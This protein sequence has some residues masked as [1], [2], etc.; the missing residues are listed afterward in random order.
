MPEI[1]SK[2]KSKKKKSET[3]YRVTYNRT[4]LVKV[5]DKVKKGDIITDGSVDLDELF[6]YGGRDKTLEYIVREVSKPYEL[7]GESVS[8][9]HIEVILRQMFSRRKVVNPGGTTLAIGDVIDQYTLDS[10]NEEAKQKGLESAKTESVIMGISEVSLSR[11]SF[12]SAASF[13]HT[14]RVLVAA[15]TRGS[16]DPLHGLMENVIIGRLIPAGSGFEGGPKAK[17]IETLKEKMLYE[18]PVPAE[19][20]VLE[21]QPS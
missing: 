11:K 3:E 16:R 6:E 20:E 9:K 8:R 18:N 13:Q 12:L 2:S 17:M 4:A 15:A 1:E 21:G 7:Q 10:E 5:G 14:T 19:G